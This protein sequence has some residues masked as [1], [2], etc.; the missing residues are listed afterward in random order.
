MSVLGF[1][2][3]S[4]AE[5]T[6]RLL[7]KSGILIRPKGRNYL[8][9]LNGASPFDEV[10]ILRP[11]DMPRAVHEGMV[12]VGFS[13]MDWLAESGLESQLEIVAT[14]PYSK[15]RMEAPKIVVLGRTKSFR[16]TPDTIVVS[17]YRVLPAQCFHQAK[18]VTVA[19]TAEAWVVG[20]KADF[21]VDLYDEGRTAK[22]NNLVI[23]GEPI[24]VSP[25]IL[26]ARKD[27]PLLP[28]IELFAEKLQE[29][30]ARL[31]NE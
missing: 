10:L 15:A 31:V 16:D 29:A 28:A 17:E 6:R 13:G 4:L 7:K 11:Q 5:P 30:F 14:F 23:V 27:S 26:L 20:G 12:T 2:N 1:P 8:L 19:G 9:K 25:T 18:L 3:G 24:I 21:C 22:A